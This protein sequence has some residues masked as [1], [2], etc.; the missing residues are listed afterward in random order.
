MRELD[1]RADMLSLTSL[2]AQRGSMQ[3]STCVE[4]G[5]LSIFF[6]SI[7]AV[8]LDFSPVLVAQTLAFKVEDEA[9]EQSRAM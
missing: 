6:E 7:A 8:V 4:G 5:L 3:S 1:K 2:V 9:L